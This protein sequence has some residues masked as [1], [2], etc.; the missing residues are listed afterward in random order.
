MCVCVTTVCVT[1]KGSVS[2]LATL[3][4]VDVSAARHDPQIVRQS[5][6]SFRTQ[7]V[8]DIRAILETQNVGNDV[9]YLVRVPN[10]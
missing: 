8:P 10:L 5:S 9:N 4:D 1:S 2:A 3:L 7:D 6:S